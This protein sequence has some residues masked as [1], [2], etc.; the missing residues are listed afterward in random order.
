[1]TQRPLINREGLKDGA[2]AQSV[3][4]ASPSSAGLLCRHLVGL[5]A[6]LS[7]LVAVT[8][9]A[10][11]ANM[12]DIQVPVQNYAVLDI[13]GTHATSN[14]G[15]IALNDDNEVAYGYWN[16]R[17]LLVNTW[18]AG[19]TSFS[20]T[21]AMQPPRLIHGYCFNDESL[22][23]SPWIS[24][25]YLAPPTLRANGDLYASL[26]EDLYYDP[27]LSSDSYLGEV[28]VPAYWTGSSR[29][30]LSVPNPPFDASLETMSDWYG[31]PWYSDGSLGMSING[32]S[33]V[34]YLGSINAAR[35]TF[36]WDGP[37]N[38]FR[39]HG[40]LF[41]GLLVNAGYI[42][43][44]GTTFVFSTWLANP[45]PS[46]YH[47]NA[48]ANLVVVPQTFKPVAM[49]DYGWAA[50]VDDSPV[51]TV[52]LW[53][54]TNLSDV[55]S[56]RAAGINNQNQVIAAEYLYPSEGYLWETTGAT[57]TFAELLPTIV[58]GQIHTVQ[59]YLINNQKS[60]P[61]RLDA[62]ASIQILSH[63]ADGEVPWEKLLWKR[64]N[65]G[66]WSF[67][68]IQ[69]PPGTIIN[70]GTTLNS[71]GVIAALGATD[72]VS[73]TTHALLLLPL[74]VKVTN[75]DDL[76]K[77]WADAK[78]IGSN[79]V[80]YSGD[81]TGDMVSWKLTGI[82]SWSSM[83]FTWTATGP[84]GETITGPTGAGRNEWKIA[85][86]D[87]DTANDWV[88]WKPGK[89]KI[90]VQ[91]GSTTAEF[92]Q[93]I[94]WRT[95]DYVVIGQIVATNAHDGDA[96][97]AT[98]T[99]GFQRAVVT[100][101]ALFAPVAIAALPA[102]YAGTLPNEVFVA[103][104]AINW[105]ISYHWMTPQGPFSSSIS[106]LGTVTEPHR[107]WMVQTG[108]N[109]SIDT[110]T[111]PSSIADSDIPATI[112]AKQ[113]RLFHHYQAKF[114]L[115]PAGKIDTTKLITLHGDKPEDAINGPTKLTLPEGAFDPKWH[116]PL[117]QIQI[118]AE[119]SPH[120]GHKQTSTDLTQ[121]SGFASGRV[122]P[123]GQNVN[124]R[125]FGRDVPW[126][127]S[128]IIFQVNPDHSVESR[129]ET[130]VDIT[131]KNNTKTGTHNFNNLNIYK[132]Q[133]DPEDDTKVNYVRQPDGLLEMNNQ[134]KPFIES[135]PL[136]TWPTP[137]I[138]PSVE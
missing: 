10:R 52:K 108:L 47:L 8:G 137:A 72:S 84:N 91:I 28:A 115:T 64:D 65:Q 120:N 118:P 138:E 73:T 106:G 34:G 21:V 61:P 7:L 67:S 79:N 98:E 119:V 55:G 60:L 77:K 24:Y 75:R 27:S 103:A 80:V 78:A 66:T 45:P 123:D 53:D 19:D 117:Y 20:Q 43:S 44:A 2:I 13:S 110:P 54:G 59:P 15:M 125:I 35:T 22:P 16:A 109:A 94:G 100:D 17:N 82:D 85:D 5:T 69:V 130:S 25:P 114:T 102:L 38:G 6:S 14:V 1:M 68:K 126:I 87:E 121:H 29:N 4:P 107:F 112:T 62:D 88:K 93:E 11:D 42:V 129:I 63:A 132:L 83:T 41:A 128:E 86:G 37:D 56:G 9:F 134:V 97:S 122:G 101:C 70:E 12:T 71:N 33:K 32:C 92:E 76:K 57:A 36:T 136:G 49:N 81:T 135:V 124:W 105:A 113:F 3:E 90:K 99:S 26:Q 133:L 96:P 39:F 23:G 18:K 74:E 40:Q 48:G 51:G 46:N 58:Q 89:W 50:G 127:F 104:E 95:E 116:N 131:W 111:A 31:N 30:E